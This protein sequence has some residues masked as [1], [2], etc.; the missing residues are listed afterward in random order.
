MN[1]VGYIFV[2][3]LIFIVVLAFLRLLTVLKVKNYN[4]EMSVPLKYIK[5]KYSLT[6]RERKSK[7]VRLYIDI[8]NTIAIVIPIYLLLFIN[9]KMNKVLLYALMLIV[10]IIIIIGGY[11]LIGLIMK[12]KDD[13]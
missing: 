9:F 4:E 7:T 8:V 10:F 1:T 13:K 5:K 6:F 2:C 12:R 11:N 3:L